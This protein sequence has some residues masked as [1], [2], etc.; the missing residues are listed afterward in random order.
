MIFDFI[1]VTVKSNYGDLLIVLNDNDFYEESNTKTKEAKARTWTKQ[2]QV[3]EGRT[4]FPV[5]ESPK[6]I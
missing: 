3:I 1:Q 4:I 2:K 6:E 5:M